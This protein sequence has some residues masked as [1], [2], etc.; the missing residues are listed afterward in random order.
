MFFTIKRCMQSI[1]EHIITQN[2]GEITL[3]PELCLEWE[4]FVNEL[5]FE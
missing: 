1:E 5:E 3:Y 4:M 2:E